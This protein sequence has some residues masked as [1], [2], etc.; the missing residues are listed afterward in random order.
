[1]SKPVLYTF[2]GSVWAA[3]PELAIIE[4]GIDV[5]KKVVNLINGENFDPAF[6]KINPNATLPT[7]EADGKVYTNTADVVSY[8]VKNASVPVKA[9]TSLIPLIHEDKYDPNFAFLLARNE[10]EIQ[11]KAGSVPGLFL[12]NRQTALEKYSAT[13]HAVPF[14]SFYE[15][16]ISGNGNLLAIYQAKVPDHVKNGFFESSKQHWENLRVFIKETLPGYLPESGFIGGE[17]PG[18]DDFHVAA[19]L[20]RIAAT[21]GGD[22]GKD[23]VKVLEKELEGPVP[24]KVANYWAAWSERESWKVTYREGLH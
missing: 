4:L 22:A 24:N 12:S 10:E 23:G 11:A 5:D 3:V 8:L 20:A 9:G 15:A 18:E 21:L 13:P 2:G 19:W 7:L 14:K 16:K 6:I 17:R 1:M